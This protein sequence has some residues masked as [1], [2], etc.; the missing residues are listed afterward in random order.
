MCHTAFS[1]TLIS[2]NG[3]AG[4]ST[5]CSQG[6]KMQ[7]ILLTATSKQTK[8]KGKSNNDKKSNGKD[9]NKSNWK[10]DCPKPSNAKEKGLP[11][12]TYNNKK[13]IWCPKCNEGVGMWV[14]H[15]PN[16]SEAHP[17]ASHQDNTMSM[18]TFQHLRQWTVDT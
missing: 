9:K 14:I 17:Q 5:A 2:T 3:C 16:N 6:E 7:C 15:H 1:Y 11:V 12:C 8:A 4:K 18:S 10:N 13:Y